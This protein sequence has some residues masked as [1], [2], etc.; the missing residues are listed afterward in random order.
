MG[1]DA[2]PPTDRADDGSRGI[3]TARIPGVTD[4]PVGVWLS[5]A[6]VAALGVV[7]LLSGLRAWGVQPAAT[8]LLVRIH[9]LPLARSVFGF[10]LLVLARGL[11]CR[12][13]LAHRMVVGLLLAS[14]V[15][16]AM[17]PT[18][19]VVGVSLALA[20]G[21]ALI[22]VRNDF[23]AQPDPERIKPVVASSVSTV[24]GTVV[25]ISAWLVWSQP[26]LHH[27]TGP[28]RALRATVGGLAGS[29]TLLTQLVPNGG[30]GLANF[31]VLVMGATMLAALVLLLAPHRAPDPAGAES[32][33]RVGGLVDRHDA[34][35]LAPFVLRHDKDY[36][37]SGD[38]QAAL[39]YRVLYGVALV[40]GDPVGDPARHQE[41]VDLFLLRCREAGWRPGV[42]GC[43][44]DRQHLWT[45][46][47]MVGIGVGDE[48]VVPTGGFTLDTPRLRNV[49]QAVK[50]S[51]NFGLTTEIVTE[52]ALGWATRRELAHVA[53]QS[54]DGQGE[55]GFSMNLDGLLNG[56]HPQ[57]V[58]VVCRDDQEQVVAFQRYAAASSGR[59]LSLDTMCRL[60]DAPNGANERMIVE[61]INWGRGSGVEAVS[62]NFAAFRA[63]FEKEE[64]S[65]LERLGHW[66][67]HRFDRY[68]KVESLYRFNKKFRPQWVPRSVVLR[69]WTDVGWMLGA[70]LGAEF[71]VP[72]DPHRPSLPEAV[73]P[74][75]AREHGRG[76]PVR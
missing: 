14:A 33:R 62:L 73:Q 12:R 15:G 52:S 53:A 47:G 24:A 46:R 63:L 30:R 36:L 20:L 58:L 21:A 44:G 4:H 19:D 37:F 40:G 55:R 64:R 50:R 16:A 51:Q 49:R 61:A 72:F 42:I 69:S 45:G 57:T 65:P 48:V 66:G 9:A 10:S 1:P 59:L 76:A 31:L 3:V 18:R 22:A 70:A 32:R 39:G 13:W 28:A 71:G 27:R 35:T 34:D 7:L 5:A 56:A 60:P 2:T 29:H 54:W 11:L 26:E 43:R 25:L 41:V 67:V 23:P 74:S 6:G 8:H 17:S 68:I 38:G 75:A